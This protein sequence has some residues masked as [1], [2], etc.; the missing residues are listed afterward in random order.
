MSTRSCIV[1]QHNNGIISNSE[2]LFDVTDLLPFTYGIILSP[3][4][5]SKISANSQI[6]LGTSDENNNSREH[7]IKIF[8][9]SC[10]SA[11]T[12]H[13]IIL[14]KGHKILKEKKHK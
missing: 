6:N 14:H 5:C 8:L 7:N 10:A 9:D 3:N 13:R 4:L 1:S 2:Q 12:A 11:S